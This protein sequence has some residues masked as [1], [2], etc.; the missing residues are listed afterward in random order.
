MQALDLK[1]ERRL[2]SLLRDVRPLLDLVAEELSLA[3]GTQARI[4]VARLVARAVGANVSSTYR[5]VLREVLVAAAREVIDRRGRTWVLV[6]V[7]QYRKGSRA[8]L[9]FYRLVYV[10]VTK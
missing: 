3:R 1:Q 8:Q 7:E 2:R 5:S 4:K 9:Q 10:L 6:E